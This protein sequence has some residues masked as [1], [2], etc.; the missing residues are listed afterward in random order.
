MVKRLKIF[1][2]L[3]FLFSF[4]FVNIS[5]ATKTDDV[6]KNTYDCPTIVKFFNSLFNK[7][8][9]VENSEDGEFVYLGGDI[10][11]FSINSKGALVVGTNSL[12]TSD[13]EVLVVDDNQII[14]GDLI[15]SI[16]DKSINEAYDIPKVLNSKE[17]LGK[18]AIIKGIRN[19]KIFYTKLKPVYDIPTKTYKLGIWVKDNISGLG[20]ITYIKKDNRFGALGHCVEDTDIEKAFPIDNGD[21][22]N[23]KILGVKKGTKGEAGEIKGVFYDRN[24]KVGSLDKNLKYGIYGNINSNLFTNNKRLIQIA[25]RNEIKPGKAKL[26]SYVS[27]EYEEYDIEIIKTKSQKTQ[28]TKSMIIKIVDK[29]LLDLT[30][31]IIQGMSGSP[32]VQNDKLVGAVTH[33]FI[34]DPTKGFGIYINWMINN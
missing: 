4:Q 26:I 9:T 3:I 31:G 23:C 30:G 22:L 13:G 25:D 10:L 11:G 29:R 33:V 17:N 21:L 27:G 16:N 20:T 6:L 34:D 28:N 24:K 2:L 7:N 5:N 15:V 32:I 12:I 14:D 1:I 18:E 8:S 19:D